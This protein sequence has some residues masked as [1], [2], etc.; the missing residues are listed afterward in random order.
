MQELEA[1]ES[2]EKAGLL[3]NPGRPYP[4][5]STRLLSIRMMLGI[6]GRICRTDK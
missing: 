3:A 4:C 2:M 1:S 6:E 5:H